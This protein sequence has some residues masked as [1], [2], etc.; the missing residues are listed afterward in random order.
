MG[1][2]QA[3]RQQH[4]K[5]DAEVVTE[6]RQQAADERRDQAHDGD[7]DATEDQPARDGIDLGRVDAGDRVERLEPELGAV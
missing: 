7:G 6:E 2:H 4:Q 1:Q 3:E 5:P